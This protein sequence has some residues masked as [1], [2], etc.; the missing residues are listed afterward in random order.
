LSPT[1]GYAVFQQTL[2]G[3]GEVPYEVRWRNT[4]PFTGLLEGAVALEYGPL[5]VASYSS[6]AT[7]SFSAVT[8]QEGNGGYT[9]ATK[10]LPLAYYNLSSPATVSVQPTT[11]TATA[12]YLFVPP[13]PALSSSVVAGTVG[14]SISQTTPGTYSS[15]YLVLSRFAN[16]VHTVDISATLAANNGTYSVMLPAGTAGTPA[17]GAYYYAYLRVWNSAAPLSSR[18]VIPINGMIDLRNTNTVTGMNVT[19][20]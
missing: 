7:L 18:K 2:P 14:G 9:V 15:G 13:S 20:P 17:P 3:A 10:G 6:G 19:L 11:A 5:H 4:N 16:I 8:P 12:P 1:S